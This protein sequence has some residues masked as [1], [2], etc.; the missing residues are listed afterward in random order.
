[1]IGIENKGHNR[2]L[3]IGPEIA[4]EFIDCIIYEK[5]LALVLV[6]HCKDWQEIKSYNSGSFDIVLDFNNNQ[7][8]KPG[9]ISSGRI[10]SFW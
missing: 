7:E 5:A 3:F 2:I 6:A 10:I 4:K 8:S 9:G 1:M